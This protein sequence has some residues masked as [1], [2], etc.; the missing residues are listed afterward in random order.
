MCLWS[1]VEADVLDLVAVRC[2]NV[3]LDHGW[4]Q[5][6]GLLDAVHECFVKVQQKQLRD[7]R[8]LE[9]DFNLLLKNLLFGNLKV[10]QEV[11]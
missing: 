6:V 9:M 11:D 8:L 10:L 4:M 7:S 1:D 3:D 5:R 2:G